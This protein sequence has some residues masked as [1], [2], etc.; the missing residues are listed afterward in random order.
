[1]L[2]CYDQSEEAIVAAVSVASDTK[3]APLTA[4]DTLP[5]EDIFLRNEHLEETRVAAAKGARALRD[6]PRISESESDADQVEKR[7]IAVDSFTSP[8]AAATGALLGLWKVNHFKS[9][10]PKGAYGKKYDLQG[11]REITVVPLDSQNDTAAIKDTGDVVASSSVPLSW[12][13]GEV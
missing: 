7:A 12:K 8:H 2:Y 5:T 6:L 10:Q 9:K 13:T 4:P 3:A 11:G 1:M